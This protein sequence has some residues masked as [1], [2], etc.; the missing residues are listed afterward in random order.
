MRFLALENDVPRQSKIVLSLRNTIYKEFVS[1]RCHA[2][3]YLYEIHV[4]KENTF[5]DMTR[6]LKD[7]KVHYCV[8]KK[9]NVTTM[10]MLYIL[11][12]SPVVMCGMDIV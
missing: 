10:S 11:T 1:N 9:V 4:E 2:Y 12:Q 5:V 6:Q 8:K 3:F 7:P